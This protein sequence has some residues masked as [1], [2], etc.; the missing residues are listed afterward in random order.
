VSNNPNTVSLLVNEEQ[1][2]SSTVSS[3]AIDSSDQD[4]EI[5]RMP[6]AQNPILR[7]QVD[8][9]FAYSIRKCLSVTNSD[10][11]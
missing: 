2:D 10:F 8:L 11:L 6:L 4:D 9:L 3:A 1:W 7:V 5:G